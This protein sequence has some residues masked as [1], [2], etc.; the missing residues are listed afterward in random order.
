M[1]NHMKVLNSQ[2]VEFVAGGKADFSDVTV[3]VDSTAK[4]VEPAPNW[5]AFLPGMFR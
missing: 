2:E 1:E 5:P 4:I 3:T